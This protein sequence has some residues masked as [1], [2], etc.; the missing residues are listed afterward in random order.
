[1]AEVIGG[2]GR[3]PLEPEPQL[4]LVPTL[5]RSHDFQDAEVQRAENPAVP[6][7]RRQAARSRRR[8]R[9]PGSARELAE[10]TLPETPRGL[11]DHQVGKLPL[12]H[13]G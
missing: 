8:S 2:E 3:S 1:M 5:D 13:R 6:N 12:E 11:V 9:G 10:H 4:A 7:E